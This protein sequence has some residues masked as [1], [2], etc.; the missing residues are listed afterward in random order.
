MQE[1]ERNST[2]NGGW[3]NV[4]EG[5]TKGGKYAAGAAAAGAA[6]YGVK[7]LFNYFSNS[8][9]EPSNNITSNESNPLNITLNDPS[10]ER[11]RETKTKEKEESKGL[12]G[13]IKSW[14]GFGQ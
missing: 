3:D 8:N 1:S 12:W 10:P 4:L 9:A 5:L 11:K 14:A 13:T 7:R 2:I 6:A